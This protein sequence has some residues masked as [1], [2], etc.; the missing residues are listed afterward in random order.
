MLFFN[1]QDN[2]KAFGF[3]MICHTI[4]ISKA[5]IFLFVNFCCG[6]E[7][8]KIASAVVRINLLSWIAYTASH[9]VFTD[10]YKEL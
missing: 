5:L 3:D 7:A 10:I 9:T 2:H 8:N 1:C 6:L 4:G